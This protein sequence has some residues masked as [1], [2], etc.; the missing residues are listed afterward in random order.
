[1][2]TD[3][4]IQNRAIRG[5]AFQIQLDGKP[6]TAYPGETIAAALLAAGVIVFHHTHQLGEPRG[7]FCCM[8]VCYDCLVTVNGKPDVRACQTAAQPGDCVER[9]L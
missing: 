1:M 5:Q 9:Q 2:N 4:R 7:P 3:L 8:G 6:L